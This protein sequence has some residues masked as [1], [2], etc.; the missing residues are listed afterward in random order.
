MKSR[1]FST[2]PCGYPS[3]EQVKA[4]E[5]VMCEVANRRGIQPEQAML[6][7]TYFLEEVA[8]KVS[9]GEAVNFPGFGMFV[10]WPA[11]PRS[12]ETIAAPRF[13]PALQFSAQVRDSASPDEGMREKGRNHA[14]NNHISHTGKWKSPPR[15]WATMDRLRQRLF[16]KMEDVTS[17]RG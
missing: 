7:V 11:R 1:I 8:D 16:R 10:P 9:R 4:L 12:G 5:D 2:P 3:K 14:D 13:F 6:T 15:V 17:V